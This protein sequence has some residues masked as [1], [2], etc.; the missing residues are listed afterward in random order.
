M[1]IA[2]SDP[3]FYNTTKFKIKML[4][5]PFYTECQQKGYCGAS[6]YLNLTAELYELMKN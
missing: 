1:I 3:N 4:C 6:L 2:S 5:Q